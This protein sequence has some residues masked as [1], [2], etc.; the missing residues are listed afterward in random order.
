MRLF[1]IAVAVGLSAG[2]ARDGRLGRLGQLRF[3]APVLVGSALA[4]Q[5][6]AGLV[7]PTQRFA[8]VVASYGLVGAW[9]VTNARR[10]PLG[11]RLGIGL[12]ALGW[13]LN[14]VAMAPHRGMPVS[15][16]AL[17][18]VGFPAGYDVADGHLFKH[19]PD[20]LRTPV[21]WL[22]DVIPVRPLG[23]VV[24]AGDLALLAGIAVCLAATMAP[25]ASRA[26]DTTR[27][28]RSRRSR[29]PGPT[30]AVPPRRRRRRR[31]WREPAPPGK[32]GG[33]TIFPPEAVAD[34][35]GGPN[36]SSPMVSP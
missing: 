26:G 29:T 20:H 5:A 23:A 9:L 11:L 10:R 7:P 18:R 21:D 33:A 2:Y 36:L 17:H 31:G 12:A 4:F 1:T 35:S 15:A 34:V 24:S 16:D 8:L 30:S 19:T 6:G 3:Q 25:P 14:A 28:I 13:L 22:G 27:I 32:D